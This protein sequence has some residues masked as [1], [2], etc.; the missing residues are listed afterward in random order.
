[1]FR[2]RTRGWG[3]SVICL[4]GDQGDS[5]G[6]NEKFPTTRKPSFQCIRGE[7]SNGKGAR[8]PYF[9]KGCYFYGPYGAP[10]WPQRPRKQSWMVEFFRKLCPEK[11]LSR[12]YIYAK[13]RPVLHKYTVACKGF[14]QLYAMAT[15]ATESMV[16]PIT[17][18]AH[19]QEDTCRYPEVPLH[20]RF[21]I[22]SLFT[23]LLF[24][25]AGRY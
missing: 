18:T 23:F 11:R 19:S 12:L 15:T 17:A 1:M 22:F 13:A 25:T 3:A 6:E 10:K 9:V 7:H 5:G 21:F 20:P 2:Q 8:R 24:G 4:Y 16:L 14:S